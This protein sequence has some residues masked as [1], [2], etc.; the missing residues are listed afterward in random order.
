ME[1]VIRGVVVYAFLFLVFRIAGKR[2]LAQSSPFELVLLLIIAETTQEAMVDGDHSITNSFLLIT[3]LIGISILLSVLKHRSE[4]AA[5][6]LDGVPVRVVRD[7]KWD[8]EVADKERVDR[9]EV[10]QSAREAQGLQR[11][12]EIAHAAVE[13]DGRISVVPHSRQ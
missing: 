2:T 6:W 11:M 10:L 5:R 7:G 9:D 4:T 13:N 1:S 8:R 3:T 12:D